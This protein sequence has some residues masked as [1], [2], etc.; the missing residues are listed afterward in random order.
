MIFKL[1]AEPYNVEV[2]VATGVSNAKLLAH[3]KRY[4][5][6]GP[7]L[8]KELEDLEK[9]TVGTWAGRTTHFDNGAL[10]IRLKGDVNG[11]W[12][13]SLLAHEMLHAVSFI[14]N[15]AGIPFHDNTEEAYAYLLQDLLHKSYRIIGQRLWK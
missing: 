8:I 12:T 14:L 2:L 7:E 5:K 10:L 11:P 6:A 1:R 4:L 15:K 3:A 9:E 13:M